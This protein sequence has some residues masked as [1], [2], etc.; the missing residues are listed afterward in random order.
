MKKV[1]KKEHEMDS[2]LE[3]TMVERMVKKLAEH[4]AECLDDKRVDWKVGLKE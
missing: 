3:H 4:W 2:Y 1:V